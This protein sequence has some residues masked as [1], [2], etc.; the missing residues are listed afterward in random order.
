MRILKLIIIFC[1]FPIFNGCQIFGPDRLQPFTTD[2]CSTFPEGTREHKD[3]WHRC[4][5]AHDQKYWAGGSYEERLQADLELRACV[6]SVGKPV[7]ADLMLAGVRVGGS[8][9][10]PSAFRWGYG[11]PYTHGYSSLTPDELEQVGKQKEALGFK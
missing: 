3:L 2:G 6:Q 9:W 1:L 11:W 8:P 10:W 5:T 7:I 4:C